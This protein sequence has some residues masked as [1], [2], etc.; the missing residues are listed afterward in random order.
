LNKGDVE[1]LVGKNTLSTNTWQ[2]LNEE[3]QCSTLNEMEKPMKTKI[4]KTLQDQLLKV[5]LVFIFNHAY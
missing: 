1:L 4:K 3:Q 2:S 5:S